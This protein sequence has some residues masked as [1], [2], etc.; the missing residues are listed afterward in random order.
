[1]GNDLVGKEKK[2]MIFDL[3][4]LS[5]VD[6]PGARA[7]VSLK[8][9]PLRCTWCCN[10]ESIEFEP[11]IFLR[12]RKCVRLEKCVGVCPQKAISWVD[13]NKIIDW[14]KCDRCGE[15]VE[16]CSAKA[17]EWCGEL[18]TVAEVIDIVMRDYRYYRCSGGGITLSGGEPLAQPQFALALLQAAKQKHLHTALDT[19]GHVEWEVL[20][21]ALEFTD[22]VLYD[23][24][25]L[26]SAKHEEVTGVSNELILANL[27][28]ITDRTEV[29]VWI[30][31][32]VI[33]GLND[34]DQDIEKLCGLVST[35]G[36]S[37]EKISLL[38]YHNLGA[39]KYPAVGKK[40]LSS[41]FAPISKERTTEI[42]SL[43]ESQGIT[44]GVGGGK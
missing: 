38:P 40:F 25:C 35:L 3:Q 27:R 2:G 34:A 24:K 5:L 28:K 33:P 20:E 15:C 22:L 19:C 14:K 41:G 31:Y 32:P 4:R 37:V 12:N 8:G 16:A 7:T 21:A 36:T 11:E 6:G 29:K 44:A 10:P 39:E 43:I 17:I 23:V 18:T 13:G 1:M 26:D 42:K 30:W 9:C